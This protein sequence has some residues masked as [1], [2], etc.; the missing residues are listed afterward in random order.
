ML[1]APV[2]PCPSR[3]SFH[4]NLRR[5][6][7]RKRQAEALAGAKERALHRAASNEHKGPLAF[8]IVAEAKS[9]PLLVF[10]NPKSGGNQ[11]AKLMQQLLWYLNPRQIFNLMAK[12]PDGKV[13]GPRPG[14]EHFKVRPASGWFALSLWPLTSPLSS[15]PP[16]DWLVPR[17]AAARSRGPSFPSRMSPTHAS[18]CAVAMAPLAGC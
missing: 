15:H 4:A 6:S 5:A 2:C 13:Q 14:L 17:L 3:K 16:R 1:T 9:Y 10:V 7:W 12:T 8:S 18:W 11:G